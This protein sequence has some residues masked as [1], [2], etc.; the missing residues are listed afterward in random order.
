MAVFSWQLRVGHSWAEPYRAL[1]PFNSRED[2]SRRRRKDEFLLADAQFE[3]F[4]AVL[5]F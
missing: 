2:M 5:S 1:T 3:Q 4:Q